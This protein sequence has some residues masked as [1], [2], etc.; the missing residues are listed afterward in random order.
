MVVDVDVVLNKI[1]KAYDVNHR[2][3]F[4]VPGLQFIDFPNGVNH[5]DF[6]VVDSMD[7]NI[8]QFR[9]YKRKNGRR[10]KPVISRGWMDYVH[11]K[12]LSYRMGDRIT[13]RVNHDGIAPF[14]IRAQRTDIMKVFG[15]AGRGWAEGAELNDW[16]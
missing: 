16:A 9:L 6:T 1:L 8:R 15:K 3:T 5:F 10:P 7:G 11:A 2:L 14:N 4:G 12:S 13:I